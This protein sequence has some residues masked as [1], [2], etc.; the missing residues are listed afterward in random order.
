MNHI[1]EKSRQVTSDIKDCS[2]LTDHDSDIDHLSTYVGGLNVEEIKD[3]SDLQ[4]SAALF[5]EAAPKPQTIFTVS[6]DT[7]NDKTQISFAQ[8]V[9][10]PCTNDTEPLMLDQPPSIM[11]LPQ[12]HYING[13]DTTKKTKIIVNS[14]GMRFAEG[15]KKWIKSGTTTKFL[16]DK[17]KK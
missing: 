11:S 4:K 10:Q 14:E 5:T 15:P 3:S 17:I 13:R 6:I 12:K 9:M 1:L 2:Q 8:L 16:A 7:T